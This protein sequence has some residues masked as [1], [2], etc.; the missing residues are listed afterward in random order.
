MKLEGNMPVFPLSIPSHQPS[1]TCTETK[2][3]GFYIGN[4][5]LS[6]I[7]YIQ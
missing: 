6:T 7:I 1:S 5:L 4:T 2:K 3:G